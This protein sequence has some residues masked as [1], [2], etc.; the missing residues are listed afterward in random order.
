MLT[1]IIDDKVGDLSPNESPPNLGL[2]SMHVVNGPKDKGCASK[3]C[4]GTTGDSCIRG[5]EPHVHKTI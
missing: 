3:G 2:S 1:G 5:I 4:Q